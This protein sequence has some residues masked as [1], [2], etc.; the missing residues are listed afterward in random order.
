VAADAVER[1]EEAAHALTPLARRAALLVALLAAFL[2]VAE[3]VGENAVK[4]VVTGEVR[5][6]REVTL[7]RAHAVARLPQVDSAIDHD[8]TRHGRFEISIVLLE[9]GIVLTSASALIGVARLMAG[10]ALLG[11]VGVGFLLA[12]LLA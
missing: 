12:G 8:E 1:H 6:V 11:F 10:G 3:V 7:D 2:A 5:V 9:V 4:S